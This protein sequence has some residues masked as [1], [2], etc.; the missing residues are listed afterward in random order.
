MS[1]LL[2]IE[3]LVLA[4]TL[5][6]LVVYTVHKRVLEL[7]Y[8]II[9]LVISLIL[10]IVACFPQLAYAAADCLGIETP[11]NLIFLLA[12]L[13]L[14]G[15]CFSLSIIVSKLSAR[16]RRLI[17]LMSLKHC[18]YKEKHPPAND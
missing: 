14:L 7:K 13:F 16:Q 5:L 10:I 12:L 15:M 11:S 4:V 6:L 9:W 1:T 2:R 17:Q 8:S 18:E 3:L